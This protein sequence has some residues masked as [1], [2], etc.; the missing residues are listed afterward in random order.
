MPSTAR[1]APAPRWWERYVLCA[2]LDLRVFRWTVGTERA[3]R[4]WRSGLV[5][6]TDDED[7]DTESSQAPGK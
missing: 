3:M 1:D 2:R 4:A 6:E 5:L 7:D